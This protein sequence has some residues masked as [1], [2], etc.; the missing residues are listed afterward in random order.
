MG[1]ELG[2]AYGEVMTSKPAKDVANGISNA[3]QGTLY[4][5]L[6]ENEESTF[7]DAAQCYMTPSGK[8]VWEL[9]GKEREQW[10]KVAITERK[11]QFHRKQVDLNHERKESEREKAWAEEYALNCRFWQDQPPS[12]RRDQQIGKYCDR[13]YKSHAPLLTIGDRWFSINYGR[14][15]E[16]RLCL[17]YKK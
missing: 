7:S 1:K 15:H 16:A 3:S 11:K 6:C 13:W 5:I 12:Q 8:R 10:M 4:T 2:K 17:T 9:E 14:N